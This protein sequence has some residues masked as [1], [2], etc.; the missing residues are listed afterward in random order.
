MKNYNDLVKLI[1]KV[2]TSKGLD[3]SIEA[4]CDYQDMI[5][6]STDEQ[7]TE[8]A[9]D[10]STRFAFYW[11]YAA[12]YRTESLLTFY[13]KHDEKI[14]NLRLKAAEL[15][16]DNAELNEQLNE[17]RKQKKTV[18]ELLESEI[19]ERKIAESKAAALEMENIKLKAKLYDLINKE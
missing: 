5:A 3:T 16:D 19:T 11:I 2:N 10:D 17:L 12:A 4:V 9:N 6:H 8:L 13:V 1:A 15:E 7:L 18:D 14:Y